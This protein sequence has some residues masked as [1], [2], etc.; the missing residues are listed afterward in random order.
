MT[1]ERNLMPHQLTLNERSRLSVTGVSDVVRFD[2]DTVILRTTLGTLIVQGNQLQLKTL[3]AGQVAVEG[4]ISA[5]YYEEMKQK[6][7]F[8]HRLFS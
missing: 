8:M 6:G 4:N 7:G 2:E 5:M 3:D 1:E